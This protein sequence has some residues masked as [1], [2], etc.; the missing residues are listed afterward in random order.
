MFDDFVPFEP[1]LYFWERSALGAPCR[2]SDD[3]QV[4]VGT[5]RQRLGG[6]TTG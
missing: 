6:P 5:G 3:A 4:G 1:L 2:R